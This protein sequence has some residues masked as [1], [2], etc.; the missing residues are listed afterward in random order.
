MMRLALAVI[1]LLAVAT[2]ANE[3]SNGRKVGTP[4]KHSMA[5]TYPH[6]VSNVNQ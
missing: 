5:L 1:L 4:N 2:N 6:D 3:N